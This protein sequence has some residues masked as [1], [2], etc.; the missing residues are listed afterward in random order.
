MKTLPKRH[1]VS[2]LCA[3]STTACGSDASETTHDQTQASSGE[4]AAS[5]AG[6]GSADGG[7]TTGSVSSVDAGKGAGPDAGGPQPV[8]SDAAAGS[9]SFEAGL[10]DVLPGGDGAQRFFLP[11]DQPTNTAA[12]RVEVDAAGNTHAVY[13]A[14]FHGDAFYT[15]CEGECSDVDKRVAVRLETDG[16]VNNAMLRLTKDGKPRVL[17]SGSLHNYW[18]ECDQGCLDRANWRL[19]R[20]Q[21]HGG[22][23]DVTGEALALDPEGRPRFLVHTYRA[24][25]GIGQKAPATSLAQCDAACTE[26]GSWRVEVIAQDELWVGS[27]FVYD[28]TGKAHVATNVFPFSEGTSGEPKAAYLSC[29]GPCNTEHTWK[30]IGFF[31]PYESTTEAVDIH[32]SI[33]LALTKAGQPRLVQLAK[34]QD[35]AKAVVYFECDGQCEGDHWTTGFSLTTNALADGVDL[36]LDER[37][38]PRFV[39]SLDYDIVLV[40]CDAADCSATD[41]WQHSY[42]ERGSD[43]P[44]DAVFLEYNCNVGGWFMH[45]PSLAWHT[46]GEPRVGYQIRDLS[47]GGPS[48]DDPSKP[49]CIAGTDMTLSRLAALPSYAE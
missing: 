11:T 44:P 49:G 40:S 8:V 13:P 19:G 34:T 18:A 30:G 10:P 2:L 42:V 28:A 21:S 45:S 1:L 35:G 41:S 32:P 14:F 48:Q 39:I 23:L 26:P 12:P 20:I 38:R 15:F 9:V 5:D 7:A 31:P 47:G 6:V 25:L 36:A 29:A 46:G 43:I 4:H 37:D 24:L 33:S 27:S 22:D 3:L 16:T 17:L